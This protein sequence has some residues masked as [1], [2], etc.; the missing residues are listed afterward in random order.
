M[1]PAT[2]EHPSTTDG[3][4]A[5]SA[6]HV[7]ATGEG[8]GTA[9]EAAEAVS[10]AAEVVAATAEATPTTTVETSTNVDAVSAAA[11][12]ASTTAEATSAPAEATSASAQAAFLAVERACSRESRSRAGSWHHVSSKSKPPWGTAAALLIYV[13]CIPLRSAPRPP[14]DNRAHR[15]GRPKCWASPSAPGGP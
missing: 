14:R 2:A 5:A 10:A 8:S 9:S 15:A 12:A 7:S 11:E 13:Y 1:T 6:Q 4:A 3:I